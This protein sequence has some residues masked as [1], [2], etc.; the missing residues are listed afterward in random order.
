MRIARFSLNNT[1]HYAFVQKDEASGKDFL[2]ELDG[3]PLGGQQ[4]QP[5]GQRYALDAEGVRLLAPVLPSKIYGLAFNYRDHTVEFANQHPDIPQQPLSEMNV[6]MKPS[7][8]VIG[9]DDPIVYP[10]ASHDLEY[11]PELVVI[12]GRVAKNV[13]AENAMDYVLGFTCGN[14]VSMRDFQHDDPMWTRAKG[15]DTS[16]PLGPWIETDLNYSD[17]RISFKLNGQEIE[18][19]GGTT[20]NLINDIPRQIAFISSFATLLPG[21]AIMTGS[22]HKSGQMHPRDEAI[23]HIDGIGDLR[24]VIVAE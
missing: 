23:V 1:P 19:A 2:V 4:V 10:S 3:Y 14:D 16:C 18:D 6:F 11:E 13:S 12:M 7:T 9:P 24:N 15:F 8:A 21:D 20:A 5:T 22:P 17:A